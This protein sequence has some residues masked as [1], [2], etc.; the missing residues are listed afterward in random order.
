M[1]STNKHNY[2]HYRYS[3]FTTVQDTLFSDFCGFFHL[4]LFQARCDPAIG[5]VK[6]LDECSNNNMLIIYNIIFPWAGANSV[7]T[8]VDLS[9][10]QCAGAL[11]NILRGIILFFTEI[12]ATLENDKTWVYLQQRI[13]YHLKKKTLD[14]NGAKWDY[15]TNNLS[16]YSVRKRKKN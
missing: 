12:R 7:Y 16:S 14:K 9:R 8:V 1:I 2:W 5:A 3:K 10:E 4:I 11:Y 13:A 15:F 6:V